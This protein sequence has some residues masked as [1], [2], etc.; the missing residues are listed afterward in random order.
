MKNLSTKKTNIVESNRILY[1]PSDFAKSSLLHI[2]EIGT[3]QAKK[4]HISKRENLNSFLFITVNSGSGTL[5]YNGQ[6][7]PVQK[8]ECIF[9]DCNVS[10]YHST[11]DD[12]W[13]ISWI[14][15]NGPTVSIIY[16]K[17]QE[18]GGSPAFIPKNIKQYN[19][20]LESLY[21]NAISSDYVR[22][23][24]INADL[25][26]L[27]TMLMIDSW[28]PENNLQSKKADT[29]EQIRE[30]LEKN[31]AKKITLDE[32]A[33]RYFINKYYLTR[34]FKK[35]YGVSITT[36]LTN[37]RIT[38]A[39]QDLRFTNKSIERIGT[40]NG[41]KELYYFSRIFKKTEGLSPQTYKNQWR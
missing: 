18:R 14:H 10:Y 1:T 12:L 13:N 38:H 33:E 36:Y 41:F 32:L 24:K 7:F 27:L 4:Q 17:Y 22:D 15:F 19:N 23:M 34:I 39:K 11:S 30:Y 25:S 2:Q 31:Y 9:I 40:D 26:S 5:H 3:L 21:N 6:D 20:I 16:N 8:G 35:K 37:I 29:L 28:N